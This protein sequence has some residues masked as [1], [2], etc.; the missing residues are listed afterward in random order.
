[1]EILAIA[2]SKGGVGKSATAHSLAS[3]FA[4]KGRTLLIDLD[5]QSSVSAHCGFFAA[6]TQSLLLDAML[7]AISPDE[8][9]TDTT[10][11]NLFLVPGTWKLY[12]AAKIF[13]EEVGSDG[14]LESMLGRMESQ[15]DKVIIDTAP[16]VS[17]LSYNAMISS[18][19]IIVPCETSHSSLLAMKSLLKVV[20]LLQQR[21]CPTVNISA[22][23][24]TRVGR[25]KSAQ[26]SIDVL[27]STFGELITQTVISEAAAIRDCSSAAKSIFQ[28]RPKSKSSAE[29]K[30]L[31]AEITARTKERRS[32]AA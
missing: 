21:R 8:A 2:Q 9:I 32:N 1:M 25:N 16:S 10:V 27:R 30:A 23:V 5:P 3:A 11:P 26:Q 18:D 20:E 13:A 6:E 7:G 19:S 12:S 29:Y 15:F 22:I 28:Y 14:L 17:V 4:E 31:A 24:P